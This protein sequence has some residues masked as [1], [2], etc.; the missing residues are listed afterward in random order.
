MQRDVQAV[1][2][3]SEAGVPVSRALT[4]RGIASRMRAAAGELTIPSEKRAYDVAYGV[5]LVSGDNQGR[6]RRQH[7]RRSR[8]RPAK[9]GSE[10]GYGW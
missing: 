10:T 1:D 9:C 5:V 8:Q 3:A 6:D 7:K 4:G 2:L